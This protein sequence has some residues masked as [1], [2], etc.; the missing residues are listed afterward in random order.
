MLFSGLRKQ[1]DTNYGLYFILISSIDHITG[2]TGKAGSVVVSLSKAGAGGGVPAGA[3]SEVDAT[4]HSG[5]YKIAGNAT[6]SNT[7]GALFL[8]AKDAASDPYDSA[9]MVVN[10]DPFTFKPSVALAPADVSG[11]LP[12]EVKAQDNIDFGALQKLSLNAATPASVQ[13]IVAQTVDAATRMAT[14]TYTAPDNTSIST[15]LT[16]LQSATY[17]L[18]ALLTAIGTRMASFTYTS[19]DSAAT[20]A[21][22]VWGAGT[23]TLTSLGSVVADTASAVWGYATRILTAGTRD[24]QIDAVK[25]K[26]DNLPSDPASN[27]QVNTRL[28]TSGYTAPDNA[29]IAAIKAKT[30]NLPASPA[31]ETTVAAVKAKTDNL[32]ASPAA[33]SDI[34]AAD[35]TAIKA[36]TDSLPSDPASNTQVNTRL[37]SAGYTAPDNADIAAIKAVTDALDEELN[38][39]TALVTRAVG[40]TGENMVMDQTVFDDDHKLTE[41]RVR[42]Y[43]SAA[44]ALAAGDAG[45]IAT[46]PLSMT[47]ASKL[48]ETMTQV[49]S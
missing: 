47:W 13:N 34:P 14:F 22:A 30:D 49:K 20:I 42:I 3:I 32:P 23:R 26:T 8:H 2:L 43:D 33:S 36:K 48:L 10:Y 17:G 35:I 6:D 45:L 31:N 44:H 21:T 1:S 46:F 11:N 37:A 27:T 16:M 18:S 38:A 15:I 19:P 28:A 40:L 5:L 7:L 9:Y 4:N 29:D 12:A 24:S 39:L 41:A 25:A